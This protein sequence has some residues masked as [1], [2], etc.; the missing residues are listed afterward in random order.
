MALKRTLTALVIATLAAACG[1]AG[2]AP[3]ASD[4]AFQLQATDYESAGI[5]A[6]ANTLSFE[7]LDEAV[8]LDARAARGIVD[9]RPFATL[10]ALDAVPYV[11][12]TALARLLTW[13]RDNGLVGACGDGIVQAHEAC[14][15]TDGCPDT[16]QL[17]PAEAVVVFGIAE[18]SYAALA[19]LD[20][21]NYADLA[22][23]DD[24]VGLDARAAQAI[25]AGRPFA[26]LTALDA[27]AYVGASAFADL[28]DYVTAAGLPGCG[29]G[30]LQAGLEACDDGNL[31]AG[32]GCSPACIIED[33]AGT[34]IGGDAVLVHGYA[35]RSYVALGM[36]AVANDSDLVT[37]DELVGL[38]ARA[39]QAIIDARAA[40]PIPSLTALDALAYV[41]SQAF[42]RLFA[43]ARDGGFIP[44][45]GDGITQPELEACDG[46]V[47]CSEVCEIASVCGNGI[48]EVTESCDFGAQNSDFRGCTQDCVA[49][50]LRDLGRLSSLRDPHIIQGH[51][52]MNGRL[53]YRG[54]AYWRFTTDV[55]VR[56]T[57]EAWS[58]S[59]DRSVSIPFRS[60]LGTPSSKYWDPRITIRD[61]QDRELVRLRIR[62]GQR[63]EV[64]AIDLEPGTYYLRLEDPGAGTGYS[65]DYQYDY[66]VELLRAPR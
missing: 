4:G 32:D 36:L 53:W 27:A 7:Q 35:E 25:V 16:C 17:A 8:G 51:T 48:W 47:G 34:E 29:D 26:S 23:L 64:T 19:I 10:E 11:G 62:L 37:L 42:D 66:K 31:D 1:E 45:C 57:G 22:T 54:V 12:D 41:G 44:A 14:D 28:L 52:L 33:A 40:G 9:A 50:M 55:P 59:G 15:G 24:A 61:A 21:A 49:T 30:V 63:G 20:L 39:A 65:T 5:L 58:G 2:P 56:L 46:E 43:F 18:G 38:D 3:T 60:P 13:A 6:A